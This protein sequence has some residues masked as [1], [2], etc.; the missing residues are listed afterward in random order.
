[1]AIVEE[2]KRATDEG[3]IHQQMEEIDRQLGILLD[4]M[5][6]RTDRERYKQL[7]DKYDNLL[8]QRDNLFQTLSKRARNEFTLTKDMIVFWLSSFKD[9]K[10]DNEDFRRSLIDCLV[11]KVVYFNDNH[12]EI[13]FNVSNQDGGNLK[14]ERKI[15]LSSNNGNTDYH[16]QFSRT[17][18]FNCS[19]TFRLAILK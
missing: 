18:Y 14:Q 11:N 5:L 19:Q 7:Y 13:Y 16:C 17:V 6:T 1:M 8:E 10:A 3:V 4:M 9:G 12:I 2:H 15:Q